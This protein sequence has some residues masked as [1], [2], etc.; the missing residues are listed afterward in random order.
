MKHYHKCHSFLC[1]FCLVIHL[2]LSNVKLVQH[3]PNLKINLKFVMLL[4][5]D[6]IVC[7]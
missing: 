2:V 5:R 6:K 1:F 3:V 7:C 4:H